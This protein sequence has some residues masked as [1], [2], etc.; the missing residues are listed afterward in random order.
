MSMHI[1]GHV[2]LAGHEKVVH[3]WK[4]WIAGAAIGT[5]GSGLL[6]LWDWT[7]Q[8]SANPSASPKN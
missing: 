2:P 5:I 3:G 4:L 6:Y 1:A 8:V 7:R